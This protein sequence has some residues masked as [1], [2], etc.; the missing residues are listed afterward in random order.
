MLKTGDYFFCQVQSIDLGQLNLYF[1][2]I[3]LSF[4]LNLT[5][6]QSIFLNLFMSLAKDSIFHL[7]NNL[8][9]N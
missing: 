4:R 5:I 6:Y 9:K 1:I 2:P 3:H 8:F 7:K